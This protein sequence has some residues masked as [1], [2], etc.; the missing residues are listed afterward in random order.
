MQT[1]EAGIDNFEASETEGQRVGLGW[2]ERACEC[3]LSLINERERGKVK[4]AKVC[5]QT[6]LPGLTYIPET[7]R[8]AKYIEVEEN[9][10]RRNEIERELTERQMASNME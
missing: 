2:S 6:I 1:R 4:K 7:R 5:E 10:K 8:L 9:T 3:F